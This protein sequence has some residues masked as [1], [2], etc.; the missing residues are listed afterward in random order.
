[1]KYCVRRK[2]GNVLFLSKL[3]SFAICSTMEK[4]AFI[5]LVNIFL[6]PRNMLKPNFALPKIQ[7]QWT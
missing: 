4:F 5:D 1:M 6:Q 3:N 2:F 7:I